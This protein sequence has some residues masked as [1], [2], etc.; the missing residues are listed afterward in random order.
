MCNIKDS[1]R[2]CVRSVVQYIIEVLNPNK[3][4]G[5]DGISHKMLKGVSKYVPKPL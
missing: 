3:A 1:V 4:S 2:F 5:G